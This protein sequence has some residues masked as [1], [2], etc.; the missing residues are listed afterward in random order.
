MFVPV[1][2]VGG[3]EMAVVQIVDMI[4]VEDRDMATIGPVH[5][6]VV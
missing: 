1:A 6:L 4:A 5:V 2:V 3:V